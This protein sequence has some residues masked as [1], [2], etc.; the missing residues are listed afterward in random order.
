MLALLRHWPPK[1]MAVDNFFEVRGAYFRLSFWVV[2]VLCTM[3]IQ[4]SRGVWGHAPPGNF[5]FTNR[6]SE[7]DSEHL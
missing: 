1:F 2:N 5:Y 3:R 7:N 6:S 4:P